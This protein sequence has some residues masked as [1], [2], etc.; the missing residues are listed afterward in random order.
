MKLF[1]LVRSTAQIVCMAL[2]ILTT[3]MV[4]QA[5]A[6]AVENT[7]N[8]ETAVKSTY[9]RAADD[10]VAERSLEIAR[11]FNGQGKLEVVLCAGEVR[12]LPSRDGRMHLKVEVKSRPKDAMDSFVRRVETQ[13]GKADI[14][15]AYPKDLHPFIT[16]RV[17]SDAGLNS[18]INLGVGHIK[19]RGDALH[20]DREL[21]V[22]V[23][24]VTIFLRG[25]TEY[26]KLFASVG[27]G[28]F[29][30]R[31]PQ[32]AAKHF[33]VSRKQQGQGNGRIVASVGVGSIELRPEE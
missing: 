7:C 10:I 6:S 20:G 14:S 9:H 22:G 21:N 11:P 25:D 29:H 19:I 1:A 15:L 4:G 17:P 13:D 32:G 23:G 24:H 5:R 28:S 30:D 33:S 27:M 31:R 8:S 16:L 12:I 18:E 26:S 2:L 3:A